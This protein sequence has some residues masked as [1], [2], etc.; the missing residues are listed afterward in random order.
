MFGCGGA[1][2]GS[3]AVTSPA[4]QYAVAFDV[5]S[6]TSCHRRR[7]HSSRD[8]R[9]S[10]QPHREAKNTRRIMRAVRS[11]LSGLIALFYI[12]FVIPGKL[13]AERDGVRR[14]GVIVRYESSVTGRYYYPIVRVERYGQIVELKPGSSWWFQWREVGEHV[15]VLDAGDRRVYVG[16]FIGRWGDVLLAAGAVGL[17]AFAARSGNRRGRRVGG[18]QAG[19]PRA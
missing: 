14:D 10:S 12:G 2:L 15:P 8:K 13:A 3:F 5:A 9:P 6:E 11:Y 18:V 4:F 19:A 17:A 1:V 16:T 7:P